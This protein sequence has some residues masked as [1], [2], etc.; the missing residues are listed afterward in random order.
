MYGEIIE[1]S[2]RTNG[3]RMKDGFSHIKTDGT[4]NNET[5][6]KDEWKEECDIGKNR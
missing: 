6:R 4:R 5:R 3:E 2:L 1:D